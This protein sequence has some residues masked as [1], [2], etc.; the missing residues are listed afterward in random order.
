MHD[1][2]NEEEHIYLFFSFMNLDIGC[3]NEMVFYLSLSFKGRNIQLVSTS[4]SP[5]MCTG[6]LE[7]VA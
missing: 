3:L 2:S 6:S 7:F 1:I 4:V 5:C